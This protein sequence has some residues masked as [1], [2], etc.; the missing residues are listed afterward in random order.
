MKLF[1]NLVD[2]K[3]ILACI[4]HWQSTWLSPIPPHI[5]WMA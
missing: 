2:G 5:N 1:K 4:V 3:W